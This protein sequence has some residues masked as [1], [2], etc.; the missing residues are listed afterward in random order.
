MKVNG[1]RLRSVKR[2]KGK[3]VKLKMESIKYYKASAPLL[4]TQ[5]C[6]LLLLPRIRWASRVLR[7][8]ALR[9]MQG[10]SV[11]SEAHTHYAKSRRRR[12]HVIKIT[13]HNSPEDTNTDTHRCENLK[14]SHRQTHYKLKPLSCN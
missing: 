11:A 12:Q 3:I 7:K 14:I 4:F 13:R 5:I 9:I 10:T 8:G 1:E 2:L 6:D